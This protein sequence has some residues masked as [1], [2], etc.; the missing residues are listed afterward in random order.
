[1]YLVGQ[2]DRPNLKSSTRA[3]SYISR[4][5]HFPLTPP[6]AAAIEQIL[7][8]SNRHSDFVDL[9]NCDPL[10]MA[11]LLRNARSPLSTRTVHPDRMDPAVDSLLRALLLSWTLEARELRPEQQVTM[12]HFAQHS[13]RTAV[14]CREIAMQVS[15]ALEVS[16]YRAGLLHDLGKALLLQLNWQQVAQ[17]YKG[18]LQSGGTIYQGELLAWDYTHAHAGQWLLET[19][20]L[21]RD[22]VIAVGA[23]HQPELIT[24][25]DEEIVR[26]AYMV[27]LADYLDQHSAGVIH[28]PVAEPLD[29]KVWEVIDMNPSALNQLIKS[30]EVEISVRMTQSEKL[31]HNREL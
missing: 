13:L 22:V 25:K 12:V 5:D 6:V 14:I 26:L 28:D 29:D 23:H 15:P 24:E 20:Q 19:W 16:A 18:T 4:L 3:Q 27:H 1:M 17:L 10:L 9:M 11:N 2:N 31:W 30:A 7:L 21:S 8:D